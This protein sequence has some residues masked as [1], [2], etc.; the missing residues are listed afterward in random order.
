MSDVVVVLVEYRGADSPCLIW[1]G[2]RSYEQ[3]IPADITSQMGESRYAAYYA[4][5]VD[6]YWSLGRR[7]DG[8]PRQNRSRGGVTSSASDHDTA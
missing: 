7:C 2:R 5:R 1:R 4:E 8:S 6:N 3:W